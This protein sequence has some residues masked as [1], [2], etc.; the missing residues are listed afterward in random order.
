M[1]RSRPPSAQVAGSTGQNSQQHPYLLHCISQQN[2]NS[3]HHNQYRT[4]PGVRAGGHTT[5]RPFSATHSV[6]QRSELPS[7][8]LVSYQRQASQARRGSGASYVPPETAFDISVALDSSNGAGAA[9]A[10]TAADVTASAAAEGPCFRVLPGQSSFVRG[11]SVTGNCAGDGGGGNGIVLNGVGA[12][13][14]PMQ[15]AA[16]ATATSGGR[17]SPTPIPMPMMLELPSP[18]P[19]QVG[20]PDSDTAFFGNRGGG[21]SGGG[22]DSMG[23]LSL[24]PLLPPAQLSVPGQGSGTPTVVP[25]VLKPPATLQPTIGL[26]G[27][28]GLPGSLAAAL[29]KNQVADVE[30]AVSGRVIHPPD[31]GTSCFP[32]L[33][34]QV[35]GP[36]SHHHAHHHH[37]H[38][39]LMDK[40]SQSPAETH[41]EPQP[42]PQPG[43]GHGHA[44]AH[45]HMHGHAHGVS[46]MHPDWRPHTPG[47][48]SVDTTA[49]ADATIAAAATAA[50][51]Q[52]LLGPMPSRL[53]V[54]AASSLSACD[55]G[56]KDD[57]VRG[58]RV[59]G[60]DE[61]DAELGT[62]PLL[63]HL[64]PAIG[65][66][67][68]REAAIRAAPMALNEEL[69][70][71]PEGPDRGLSLLG[72]SGTPQRFDPLR[73]LPF[74]SG[75]EGCAQGPHHARHRR[76]HSHDRHG[77][78][79]HT[80]QQVRLQQHGK[81]AHHQQQSEG[82]EQGQE[83]SQQHLQQE[84]GGEEGED[85]VSGLY[86]T[87]CA[88]SFSADDTNDAASAPSVVAPDPRAPGRPAASV[89]WSEDNPATAPSPRVRSSP[90]RCRLLRE[91]TSTSL[92]LTSEYAASL[93]AGA[94]G[95]PSED[96]SGLAA[97]VDE[98]SEPVSPSQSSPA[99]LP[100]PGEITA[101]QL[102][103]ETYGAADMPGTE[104]SKATGVLEA[105]HEADKV[106]LL[107]RG[108]GGEMPCPA[109]VR[110]EQQKQHQEEEE[111]EE[112]E[113]RRDVLAPISGRVPLA[114]HSLQRQN[115]GGDRTAG[116]TLLHSLSGG[117][118]ESVDGEAVST[119]GQSSATPQPGG[120]TGDLLG[121]PGGS[122][123]AEQFV[124]ALHQ[125]P[126]DAATIATAEAVAKVLGN[127]N[128]SHPCDFQREQLDKGQSDLPPEHT[129]ISWQGGANDSFPGKANCGAVAAAIIATVRDALPVVECLPPPPP[130]Q[131]QQKQQ[132]PAATQAVGPSTLA[133]AAARSPFLTL[134]RPVTAALVSAAVA[135]APPSGGTRSGRL[136]V[137]ERTDTVTAVPTPF[138]RGKG[139]N[140]DE[141][142]ETV[143]AQSTD[144]APQAAFGSPLVSALVFP[145]ASASAGGVGNEA[146]G[147]CVAAAASASTYMPRL[148]TADGAPAATSGLAALRYKAMTWASRRAAVD[149][150]AASSRTD[151]SRFTSC[152]GRAEGLAPGAAT[153]A[154]RGVDGDADDLVGERLA[155]VMDSGS[156]VNIGRTRQSIDLASSTRNVPCEQLCS[157][158]RSQGHGPG[159]L[160]P[161]YPTSISGEDSRVHHSGGPG[162]NAGG[163]GSE[164]ALSAARGG[165]I[166]EGIA[167]L[168]SVTF[169]D[170][171]R[172]SGS[173]S[174]GGAPAPHLSRVASRRS[175]GFTA[176]ELGGHG[177]GRGGGSR[178]S[179]GSGTSPS[180]ELR[181]VGRW[182]RHSEISGW[183]YLPGGGVVE[184]AAGD[185]ERRGNYALR[186]EGSLQ[187]R[188]RLLQGDNMVPE[189]LQ[190]GGGG[191][192]SRPSGLQGKEGN[193]SGGQMQPPDAAHSPEDDLASD[194]FVSQSSSVGLEMDMGMA[195]GPMEMAMR[196]EVETEVVVP[197]SSTSQLVE[198]WKAPQVRD[199]LVR[200]GHG[201]LADRFE[202]MGVTG[203]ALC[204]LMRVMR[205]GGGA[206]VVR[207]MLRNE[208][209]V[210]GL[211]AQLELLEELHR[212]FD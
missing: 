36:Q 131:Q 198:R 95:A 52:Q 34:L 139:S 37:R 99:L 6:G 160:P 59:T 87:S 42:Y 159:P 188:Q 103:L 31:S 20:D 163:L 44:H 78:G 86:L 112:E 70:G 200:I 179:I 120:S 182:S 121:L 96:D 73:D 54:P 65:L 1:P 136:S 178:A 30:A 155:M 205:G 177:G 192:S 167:Q 19:S 113:G 209:G 48:D 199:W 7:P 153:P 43:H 83:R 133:A 98:R 140:L 93:F 46:H 126:S 142:L 66:H 81:G 116:A 13:L 168:E 110:E 201:G 17:G 40:E 62:D 156:R 114:R 203:R 11:G 181:T 122:N 2:G 100:G 84:E 82:H 207:D 183:D 150:V 53:T 164:V 117:P 123:A 94:A 61:A 80:V 32:T 144:A 38:G 204:G 165:E 67:R 208:L 18:E 125:C 191:F 151:T 16:A 145:R 172:R 24:P 47:C 28:S 60:K 149:A 25:R 74:G 173:A 171:M 128:H 23:P 57:D 105:G 176:G 124:Q 180:P 174:I 91:N 210:T 146:C 106:A 35:Q 85:M 33:M 148:P 102:S 92:G 147:S 169:G 130:P 88:V 196:M 132:Q 22:L 77:H 175:A 109:Q 56:G 49:I 63:L 189:E 4:Q 135:L 26:A 76:H 141:A 51:R 71:R 118:L 197:P 108:V 41:P 68:L 154:P 143:S 195:D 162:A 161:L 104:V 157:S 129:R 50:V 45:T 170:P 193:S 21:S 206:A 97:A 75:Y 187:R 190:N 185:S 111:E 152:V 8:S 89:R 39:D 166:N 212:L 158:S 127:C 134:L 10:A 3:G 5:S 12:I 14:D 64:P 138:T 27:Q 79:E 107:M 29:D 69:G 137:L 202:E 115:D 184:E 9:T 55:C 90:S 186:R 72:E 101:A 119:D 58:M 194:N 211:A 15:G